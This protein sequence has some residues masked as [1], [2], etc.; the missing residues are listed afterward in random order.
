MGRGNVKKLV[1]A[2]D[3]YMQGVKTAVN[4]ILENMEILVKFYP[5]HIEKEDKHFF[6][7]TMDYLS[8]QEKEAMLK[9]FNEFDREFIHVKYKGIVSD[10]GG[11]KG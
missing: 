3:Y 6:I 7:P 1:E 2:R 9:E 5:K 10:L 4:G 8:R 11:N